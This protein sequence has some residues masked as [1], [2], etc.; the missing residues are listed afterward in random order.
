[1]IC[2]CETLFTLYH[3]KM[4]TS[5]GGGRH[6]ILS[7]LTNNRNVVKRNYVITLPRRDLKLNRIPEHCRFH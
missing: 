3:I 7:D 5:L 1:M 4:E 2:L 6:D